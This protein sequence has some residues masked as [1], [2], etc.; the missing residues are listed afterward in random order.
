[1]P[2][3]ET[4][5]FRISESE[6]S[7]FQHNTII[8]ELNLSDYGVTLE[9]QQK[10]Q[11]LIIQQKSEL[12]QEKPNYLIFCE[13]PHVYTLGKSGKKSNLLI[14]NHKLQQIGASLFETNRGGDITY[15]GPG[16]IVCYPIFDLD[17]F[18]TGIKAYVNLLEEVVIRTL[19]AFNIIAGRL[20]GATGV[21]IDPL[22]PVKARKICA[23][24]V[25]LKR[26]VT[27]HGF[28]LNINTDLNYFSFINPCGFTDKKVTSLQKETGKM[29]S[30]EIIKYQLTANFISLF[31]LNITGHE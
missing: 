26:Q 11:N 16:Q 24:G 17:E 19:K 13:H 1:M 3:N 27:M 22:N 29:I 23:I 10:L 5:L 15:H 7:N 30:A 21:W 18:N 9:Y 2:V 8:K 20:S 25:Y 6:M 28:A 4:W 31:N 12:S 14:D